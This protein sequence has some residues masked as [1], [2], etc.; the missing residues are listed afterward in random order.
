MFSYDTGSFGKLSGERQAKPPFRS[1]W[2]SE[3]SRE[4][5][6]ILTATSSDSK[7]HCIK[8][9]MV[10][11]RGHFQPELIY[12]SVFSE[13]QFGVGGRNQTMTVFFWYKCFVKKKESAILYSN[14]LCFTSLQIKVNLKK[15]VIQ[16][17]GSLWKILPTW[18]KNVIWVFFFNP[19]CRLNTSEGIMKT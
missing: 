16:M 1:L 19:C 14:K 6:P 17:K 7:N 15:F 10:F 5:I 9:I 18:I 4:S 3:E 2:H 11:P 13:F 12:D 8:T